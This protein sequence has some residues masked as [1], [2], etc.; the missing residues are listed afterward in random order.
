M[1]RDTM[2]R[3]NALMILGTASH[4]GKSILTAGLG[5]IFAGDGYRVAPFKAQNMSLNSAATLDGGEIGRAQ[6]LQAEACRAVASVEMN[7]VLLKPSTDTGA[8]VIL[9]GKIWGQVTASDYHTRRVEQ[10]FPAVLEAYTRLA[11]RHD[12]ILLEGAG[13]PAEINLREHDIV[14]MRMAHAA[15]AACLLVGDIDRGGVFGSLLGTLELLE[16]EDR[17]RIRGFVIN[18]FRGDES[19]LRPGVTAM[20]RR[21]GLPCV[22]IVP[23]LPGLGLDEEDG[24]ALEDRPSVA[25]LW[26]NHQTGPARP[27]RIGVIALPHMANFTDFDPLALEPSVS[28]A[29]LEYREEMAAA[30]LL[31][32]PG[33]K[34]TLDDLEWLDRR[35]FSQEFR[36][37]C[38]Q[39]TPVIG[40]CGGFQMLGSAIEDPHGVENQGKSCGR[41]GLGFLPVQTVLHGEKTVRRVRGVV[42]SELFG[43]GLCPENRFDGYEIHVGE[44][45]Y[46]TGSRA[47]AEIVRQGIPGSTPDGAVSA[48]N[49]VLGTYVHGLFDN[50]DFRHSFLAALRCAADLAP[51]KIWA[52]VSAERE[53]RIDRLA[54]HLRKSLDMNLIRSWIVAP[55]NGELNQEQPDRII[56]EPGKRHDTL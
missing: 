35:G 45:L 37:L 10:L 38:E 11:H 49:R 15:D 16:P 7:P 8:Q 17:Q 42:R 28:L 56:H 12:L 51:A 18:K 53:A 43:L 9:L 4:V 55:R 30:D 25:R 5:R 32:L 33:S 47:F 3:K 50:D 46:E 21:L 6:A 22:G 44:T 48:S 14:N 19:L 24:V 41:K 23:Y 27:V 26:K 31:I 36:R 1:N 29:F 34:Q 13:S 40:I 54:D 2:T 52:N 20:E 39:G